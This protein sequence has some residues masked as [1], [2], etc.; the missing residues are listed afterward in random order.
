MSG[1]L[2]KTAGQAKR[3]VGKATGQRDLRARGRAQE[4][5][6]VVKE[7]ATRAGRRVRRTVDRTGARIRAH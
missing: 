1:K 3:L 2:T 6:G 7:R 5:R 4:V